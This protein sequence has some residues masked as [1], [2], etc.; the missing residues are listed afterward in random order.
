MDTSHIVL[1]AIITLQVV[2]MIVSTSLTVRALRKLRKLREEAQ[3][4][5]NESRRILDGLYQLKGDVNQELGKLKRLHEKH[6]N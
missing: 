5:L 6:L 2:V 3:G 1:N 4:N